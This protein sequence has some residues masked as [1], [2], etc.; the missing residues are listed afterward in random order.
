MIQRGKGCHNNMETLLLLVL[1]NHHHQHLIN[2]DVEN[3]ISQRFF[4]QAHH[5]AYK[6]LYL[7]LRLKFVHCFLI[8]AVKLSRFPVSRAGDRPDLLPALG[9]GRWM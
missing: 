5:R 9:I 2:A 3:E 4:P 8:R 7:Y 1:L 6:R